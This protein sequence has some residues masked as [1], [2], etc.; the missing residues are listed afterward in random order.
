MVS[1][2]TSKA[3]Q[4]YPQLELEAMAV[5]YVLVVLAHILLVS[6]TKM[7]LSQTIYTLLSVFN[8]NR[9]GSIRTEGIKLRHQDILFSL[10]FGNGRNNPADYLTGDATQW[11]SVCKFERE[12]E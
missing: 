12:R 2:S 7:P 9:S 5:D 10:K 1:R 4:N 6:N 8:G 11:K 3:E